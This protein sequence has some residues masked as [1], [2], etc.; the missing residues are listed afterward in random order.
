MAD[1]ALLEVADLSVSYGAIRAL[2]GVSLHVRE[3]EIVAVLGPNGAGKSTL[4]KAIT[5]VVRP[6]GGAIRFLGERLDGHTP[7]SIV[8]RGVSMVPEGRR[9]FPGL[10]VRENLE[11]GGYTQRRGAADT[12]EVLETF[13]IL[14]DRAGQM[15]GTLS[16]GEQ[17]QL[18]IARSL[19]ARPRLMLLDEPSLGL[20]PLIVDRIMSLLTD[21]RRRGVTILLVEQNVHRALEIADRAYVLAVGQVVMGGDAADLARTG[22]LER[23][24]L[25]MASGP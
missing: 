18:A 22:S 25:G 13:P 11:V 2:R 23:T 15:A 19:M 14:A 10:T 3:G 12:R 5:G 7:E 21:L 20:A 1:E 17:Q 9:L 16:G 4:L 24:Y 6:H 8:R